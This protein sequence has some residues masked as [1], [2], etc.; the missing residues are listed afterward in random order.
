[1]SKIIVEQSA[2]VHAPSDLVY[3]II[4][5]Y[6]VGHQDIIPKKYFKTFHIEKGGYGEGTEIKF[7]MVVM[8]RKIEAHQQVLEPEPG[9]VLVEQDVDSDRATRFVVEPDGNSGESIVTITT[10]WTPNGIMGFFERFTAPSVLRKIYREEL[11]IL[12][13]Y[14]AKKVGGMKIHPN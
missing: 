8:G 6:K 5:D 7:G 12:N 13:S 4:A 14:A 9:K 2:K 11:A 3:S 1:M 10:S